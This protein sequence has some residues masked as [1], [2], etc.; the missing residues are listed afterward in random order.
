VGAA[1]VQVGTANFR[2]PHACMEIIEG[3]REF[4]VRERISGLE[5]YRGG[6]LL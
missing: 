3:I 1:A 6:L 4:L 2:N 5:E